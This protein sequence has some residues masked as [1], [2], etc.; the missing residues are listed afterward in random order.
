MT[1][2]TL[3]KKAFESTFVYEKKGVVRTHNKRT[4]ALIER[5]SRQIAPLEKKNLVLQGKILKYLNAGRLLTASEQQT[6]INNISLFMLEVERV[7]SRVSITLEARSTGLSME[8][9]RLLHKVIRLTGIRQGI[10]GLEEE[11]LI[12]KG[13]YR[14]CL[15]KSKMNM[16]RKLKVTK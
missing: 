16:K 2:V 5:K 1:L 15:E 7:A 13:F 11:G 3:K 8:T 12:R 10:Y 9:D 4:S 14:R 6:L